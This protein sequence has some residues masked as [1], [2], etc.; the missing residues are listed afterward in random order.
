MAATASATDTNAVLE[1]WFAAQAGVHGLSADFVQTRALKTLVQP[2]T[3]N[4]HL[5]FEPPQQFRWELGHPP[6]TIALRHDDEMYVIYP[7]LKRAE[8]Y[9]LGASAPKEWR[10][11]MALLTAGFPNVR[12]QFDSQ[13]QLL[14]LTQ[15]NQDWVLALQ[16]RQAAARALLPEF[17]VFLATNNFILTGTELVFVDGSRMRNDFTNTVVN[18]PI[19]EKIFEWTQPRGYT[20]TEPFAK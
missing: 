13:F 6:R 15:S 1:A 14:S 17:R 18:P 12:S 3:A 11:A 4:G 16:P 9:P 10:D 5:W 20:V 19:D 2:L 7:Q 8:H